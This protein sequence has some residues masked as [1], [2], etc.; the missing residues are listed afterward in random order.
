MH[1]E[2]PEPAGN[3][4]SGKKILL[5]DGDPSTAATVSGMLKQMGFEVHLETSGIDAFNNFYEHP[6]RFDL[7]ITDQGMP[8]I[9][10]LLLAQRLVRVRSDIPI[11]LMTGLEGD[12]QV[13][14]RDAGVCE[15]AKKPVTQT[16]L[17][18]AIGRA[19]SG[20]KE[21]PAE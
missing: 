18:E 15:F 3:E 12:F 5:V 10:G 11:V 1:N 8:D 17:A 14:A 7:V 9:S 2:T 16:E 6:S 21:Q 4:N 19:L 20:C 13:R